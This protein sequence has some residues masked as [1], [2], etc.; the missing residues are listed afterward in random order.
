MCGSALYMSNARNRFTILKIIFL[1]IP[2]MACNSV[3]FLDKEV[4]EKARQELAWHYPERYFPTRH[5]HALIGPVKSISWEGRYQIKDFDSDIALLEVKYMEFHLDGLQVFA[6]FKGNGLFTEVTLSDDRSERVIKENNIVAK[7]QQIEKRSSQVVKIYKRS[8]NKGYE[9]T[10]EYD[11]PDCTE[12]EYKIKNG[13]EEQLFSICNSADTSPV[14]LSIVDERGLIVAEM[15]FSSLPE[16]ESNFTP[17]FAESARVYD[18]DE[19]H[20][21]KNIET[22]SKGNVVSEE[23]FLYDM[24]GQLIMIARQHHGEMT[25]REEIIFS[26]HRVDRYGNWTFRRGEIRTSGKYASDKFRITE[27]RRRIS[28]FTDV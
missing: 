16:S 15:E 12:I 4:L 25:W 3:S 10:V 27:E 20:R 6:S 23:R 21:R 14:S 1:I 18:Y 2:L 11:A 28:Y 13:L 9:Q 19:N 7:Q 22:Y 8:D 17:E 5:T 24:E 26:K